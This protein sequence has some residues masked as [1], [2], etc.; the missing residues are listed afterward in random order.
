MAAKISD[1]AAKA[2]VSV[3][4]VSNVLNGRSTVSEHIAAR[5]RAAVDELRYVR[6]DAARQLRAGRSRMLALIVHDAGNPFFAEIA[7]GAEQRA[8]DDGYVVLLCSSAQ[9]EDRERLYIEQFQQQR[10]AGVLI[11]PSSASSRAVTDLVEQGTAVVVVDEETDI[12]GVGTVSVD[13]VEGGYLAASHLLGL[14]RRNLI[15]VSGPR[16]V[17]QVADRLEGARRAVGEVAGAGLEVVETPALTVLDGRD[18]GERLLQRAEVPDAVFA[19]NDLLA[20]GVLQALTMTG[21]VRVPEDV[22]LIGYDD[23]DFAAAAV[24]PLSSIRQS[25][26]SMGYRAVDILLHDISGASQTLERNVQFRPSVVA[27]ASTV[28]P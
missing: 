6:N 8:A 12:P 27:R 7:R 18:A 20:L 9:D 1:V 2:G 17:R 15:Y 11:A 10:V 13:D 24:V 5:V 21:R 19:A 3:G 4:T 22:A 23:I 14:G 16:G 25:A 26:T 28:G